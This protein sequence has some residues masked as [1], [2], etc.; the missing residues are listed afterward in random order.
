MLQFEKE[1]IAFA[2]PIDQV[3][4]TVTSMVE[5]FNDSEKGGEPTADPA[6]AMS[7]HC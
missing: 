5:Q 1:Q 3:I 2:I 6:R 4:D 7:Y